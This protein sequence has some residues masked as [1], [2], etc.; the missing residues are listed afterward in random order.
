MIKPLVQPQQEQDGYRPPF[1]VLD[2]TFL[3]D[4]MS[5]DMVGKYHPLFNAKPIAKTLIVDHVLC[6]DGEQIEPLDNQP[7][8][9]WD[10]IQMNINHAT[11]EQLIELKQKC[12]E[13]K[14]EYFGVWAEPQE[15]IE[16]E[17]EYQEHIRMLRTMTE[18]VK[19]DQL[20]Q[21]A[22]RCRELSQSLATPMNGSDT[23]D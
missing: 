10:R 5:A 8:S 16:M 12:H 2:D 9:A 6:K 11:P 1:S 17:R 15:L 20:N 18:E 14:H 23:D 4:E 3:H 19:P 22:D 7:T 13:F 21:W